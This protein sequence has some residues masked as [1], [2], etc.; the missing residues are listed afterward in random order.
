MK[1]LSF[2]KDGKKGFGVVKGNNG[3]IELGSRL[4]PEIPD[5]KAV[6][7]QQ[8]QGKIAEIL[9]STEADFSLDDIQYDIPIDNAHTLLCIGVNY[10]NRNAEY[11]DGS[12]PPKY[13]SMFLRTSGSFTGHNR[14]LIRPPETPQLD[15][16]GEICIVIGKSGRRIPKKEA[17]SY[18]AGL[19]IMNE[20]TLRDW[21]RHAKFNVTQGKNFAQSG[22]IGPWI[23]TMD[24]IGDPQQLLNYPVKTTVNGEV[25]QDD[26]TS[27]M[28]FPI[29]YIISYVSTFINLQPGDIIATGT[30]T[31]AGA[32]F[33]PPK[34]LAPGDVVEVTVP[35]VGTL[36]NGIEDED[37]PAHFPEPG[38]DF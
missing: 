17:L 24:E 22:A 32:R 35:G 15:Y 38:T 11:K 19:T 9:A 20:G 30:P 4:G 31:G 10:A 36:S 3:V 14:P 13:P 8:A 37:V 21:V 2:T 34:Y 28:R 18:V 23:V 12:E 26:V 7:A 27:I 16:E 1:L 5:L 25:R 33:D 29:D 6:F